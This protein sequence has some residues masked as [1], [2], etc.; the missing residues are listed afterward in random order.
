MNKTCLLLVPILNHST[1]FLHSIIMTKKNT[2]DSVPQR[3]S[4]LGIGSSGKKSPLQELHTSRGTSHF[5]DAVI[6]A[7]FGISLAL[8]AI[9]R[10][11]EV[12]LDRIESIA[13][14]ME[15]LEREVRSLQIPSPLPCLEI[16]SPQ[17][18]QNIS[19]E[20]MMAWLNSAEFDQ[21]LGTSVDI[22]CSETP[23][24]FVDLSPDQI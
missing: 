21:V 3:R 5:E 1:G 7:V 8:G 9:T 24:H 10:S 14:K 6:S 18:L 15:T 16:N 19:D 17:N 13:Q 22:T 12:L 2:P 20:E 11:Q 4:P 23:L